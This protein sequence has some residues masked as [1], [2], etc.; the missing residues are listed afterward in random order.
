MIDVRDSVA[1]NL[2]VAAAD[3]LSPADDTFLF[4]SEFVAGA[5]DVVD[6]AA[7]AAASFFFVPLD[8]MEA[9]VSVRAVSAKC[10]RRQLEVADISVR[11]MS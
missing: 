9:Q 1:L 3:V 5:V 7:A 11:M 10:T 2:V 6:A 8:L 4:L